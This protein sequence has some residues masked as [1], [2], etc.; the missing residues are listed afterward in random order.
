MDDGIVEDSIEAV[1]EGV[2]HLANSAVLNT[3]GDVVEHTTDV[4]HDTLREIVKTGTGAVHGA[5]RAVNAAD[6]VT[7]TGM[8]DVDDSAEVAERIVEGVEEAAEHCAEHVG[9]E[10]MEWVGEIALEEA[11]ESVAELVPG[12]GAIIPFWHV[13][14]GTAKATAGACGL[15][16]GSSLALVGGAYGAVAA[17]FDGG[18]AWGNV[19]NA[20]KAPSAWGVS[21]GAEGG[22]VATKGAL[23]FANQVFPPQ[24]S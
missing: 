15:V 8:P 19:M 12:V 22:L 11:A 16:A 23:G 7:P 14:N 20:S 9:K 18:A 10:A 2:E 6:G 17:P 5:A 4:V 1:V 24:D 13:V 21:M 3:A